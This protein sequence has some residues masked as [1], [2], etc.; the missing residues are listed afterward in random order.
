MK[1]I[2][3]LNETEGENTNTGVL[4]EVGDFVIAINP[5][6]HTKPDT[7]YPTIDLSLLLD[8]QLSQHF[9]SSSNHPL[10]SISSNVWLS[11]PPILQLSTEPT[12]KT[13]QWIQPGEFNI[14]NDITCLFHRNL[15]ELLCFSVK[16]SHGNQQLAYIPHTNYHGRLIKAVYGVDLLLIEM[17][18]GESDMDLLEIVDIIISVQAKHTLV[19]PKGLNSQANFQR[20]RRHVDESVHLAENQQILDLAT[21]KTSGHKFKKIYI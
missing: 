20:I 1:L 3:F 10:E 4:I 17:W 8:N 9:L 5:M 16:I 15:C 11:R 6:I 18:P 12:S 21:V 14:R 7:N 13:I 19:I 2:T